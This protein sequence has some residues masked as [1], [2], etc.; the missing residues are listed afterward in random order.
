ME[1]WAWSLLVRHK[2]TSTPQRSCVLRAGHLRPHW[3]ARELRREAHTTSPWPKLH[4]ARVRV[5][6]VP[7]GP[8]MASACVPGG[9]AGLDKTA[10]GPMTTSVRTPRKA[11]RLGLG[12]EA[13]RR[14]SMLLRPPLTSP[15]KRLT[16][17]RGGGS[18]V[19]G[20]PRAGRAR[21]AEV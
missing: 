10:R 17:H 20:G 6:F 4:R 14:S 21:R 3:R 12:M 9:G 16:E 15:Q 1:T 18:R 11:G 2:A 7:R 8:L 19:P 5:G 13:G